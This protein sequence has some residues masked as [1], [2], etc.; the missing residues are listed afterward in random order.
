M[1]YPKRIKLLDNTANQLSK[2]K[3]KNWIGIT[4]N[5]NGVYTSDAEIK[6]KSSML[7]SSLCDYNDAYIVKATIAVENTV[8]ADGDANNINKKLIFK[9]CKPFKKCKT[10]INSTQIDN[11]PNIHVVMLVYSLL[12]NSNTYSKT[13][14]Q[15]SDNNGAIAD[16]NNDNTT[17]LL[18]FK[19]K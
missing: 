12:E 4:D 10:K 19:K 16:F 8:A 13:D 9:N 11:D 14:E 6:L 5:R 17:D 15:S 7:M 2:F 18:K 1:E 3:T